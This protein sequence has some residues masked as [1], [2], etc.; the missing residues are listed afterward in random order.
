ML[1]RQSQWLVIGLSEGKSPAARRRVLS[2][3]QTAIAVLLLAAFPLLL[4]Q[5]ISPSIEDPFSYPFIKLT[6]IGRL[7]GKPFSNYR[8]FYVLSEDFEPVIH[9]PE[10]ADEM[11]TILRF[12]SDLSEK[13]GV[14]WTHFVD[15]N[16]LAPAFISDDPGLKL[17]T[18]Q[19]IEDLAQM[20]G[21]GDDCELHLHGGMDSRLIDYMR[22][23]ERLKIKLEGIET[24]H[25][26]RQRK[27]F[28]FNSFNRDGYRNT[29]ASLTY[30]KRLLEDSLYGGKPSVLGF[31]PGGWDH[32]GNAEE[33][34]IYFN[35]LSD[36]GLAF[37]SGLSSG[38]F[39][40]KDWRVGNKP[41]RN[42]AAVRVGANTIF[43]ISPTSGPGGYVNP[44]LDADLTK[45]A[46]SPKD[47]IRVI[48]SVFHL[49]QLQ[50]SAVETDESISGPHLEDMRQRLER[51]FAMVRDLHE[52][53][54][55][56]PITLR[57][58]YALMT[59]NGS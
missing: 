37:N 42:L 19:M 31:R 14:P 53:G 45:L 15:V 57:E 28:F 17:R 13:N 10:D 43:E 27:S 16:T 5:C 33:T 44:M 48:V 55:L 46:D 29:V 49:S 8:A 25:V 12:A 40:G 22:A 11:R 3:K 4:T 35:A 2:Y 1:K 20:T 41:G 18:T 30:G 50:K 56:Y 24:A 51:H 54:V 36:A 21:R 9:T 34:F 38:V 52:K 39:G 6:H 58:L 32:G 47:E 26:S 7:E 23:K 59:A